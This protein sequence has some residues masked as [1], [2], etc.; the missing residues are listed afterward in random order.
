MQT[1]TATHNV[2][3][4][5]GLWIPLVTPFHNGEVDHPALHRLV[6]HYCKTGVAGFVACGSTGEA[7]ALDNGE[8]LAVLASVLQASAGLP[9]V[10]GISGCHMGQT[11]A[12]V[13]TLSSYPIA[14]LLVPAPQYIRPS[15][16]GLLHWF[17]AIADAAHV[18][19]L[20]Y[21]VPYRTGVA[22]TLETLLTLAGHP[23]IRAIKDCGGD[24]AKTLALI[25][26]GRLNVL[27]GD[28]AQIFIAVA[29]GGAGA[30][31]ASAHVCTRRFAEVI[32]LL[33][34]EKLFEARAAWTPL[35]PVIEAMFAEP[36]PASIKAALAQQG[37]LENELRA[38]MT[39]AGLPV[40]PLA[41]TH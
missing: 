35:V 3:I 6:K 37:W 23:N 15:Q 27:A 36:N 30:I 1:Q 28:D 11:L 24:A 9:V 21:D 39:R 8:Q 17:R 22:I 4:F 2:E 12:W 31:A 16:A 25:A 32:R 18:P 33:H 34:E 14:G 10:M 5:S 20:V 19:L 29:L 40:S 26:D 13:K 38:P 41:T 7:A